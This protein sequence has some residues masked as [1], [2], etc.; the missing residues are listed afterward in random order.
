MLHSEPHPLK[1]K[2][3]RINS[4]KCP[5]HHHD[6]TPFHGTETIIGDWADC[7]WNK[8]WGDMEGNPTAMGYAVRTASV[9]I[10]IDDDD[11]VV[12]V[13]SREFNRSDLLHVSE[14]GEVVES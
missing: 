8:S 13:H 5:T 9:G 7:M 3:I 2:T 10:D 14:I 1:G 4:P 12:Y 11:Q 6:G